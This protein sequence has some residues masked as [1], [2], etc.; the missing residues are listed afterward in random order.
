LARA[1]LSAVNL[2][3]ANLRAANLQG[4]DL[5]EARLQLADL[6]E[7]RLQGADLARATLDGA[8]LRSAA[9]DGADLRASRLYGADLSGASIA[10]ADLSS[11]HLW[12][13]VPPP[14][15]GAVLADLS[16][17][18]I[19]APSDVEVGFLKAAL[20]SPDTG[21]I[22]DGM[23]N[24][25][26]PLTDA[27]GDRAWPTGSPVRVRLR[28]PVAPWPWPARVRSGALPGVVGASRRSREGAPS[29]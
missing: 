23:R 16:G 13:A 27:G 3:G 11:A 14:E 28:R 18:V 26:G 6:S 29:R 7:A 4:A 9:L 15:S 8:M 22:K 21:R 20:A 10:G 12:R 2:Q 5:S 17:I 25:I 24:R 19:K 1:A